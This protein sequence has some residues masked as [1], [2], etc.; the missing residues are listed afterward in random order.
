ME[1]VPGVFSES[2][3]QEIN[4]GRNVK[5]IGY[6]AFS[7]ITLG[8]SLLIPN[9]IETIGDQAF[10]SWNSSSE[11]NLKSLTFE[12]GSKLKTIGREAFEGNFI[13]G[14]LTIPSGVTDIGSYAFYSNNIKT[15]V[16]SGNSL[17]TID[18][19]AFGSNQIE[20][21][22]TF[23]ASVETINGRAFESNKIETIY[24][25]SGIK[26]IDFY[27]FKMAD[28]SY[29]K[30]IYVDVTRSYWSSDVDVDYNFVYYNSGWSINYNDD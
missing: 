19:N 14:T 17:K 5:T 22:V 23:P 6:G 7:Y 10:Y 13:G 1:T 20:G 16:F 21:T 8:S 4:F 25:G 12:E 3:I 15:L 26:K 29:L 27:A 30:D 18:T 24:I 28:G 2:T 11:V 9:N